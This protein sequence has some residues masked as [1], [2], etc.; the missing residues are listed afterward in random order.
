M[1]ALSR[2]PRA[3]FGWSAA[4]EER[5][6]AALPRRD[7]GDPDPGGRYTGDVPQRD[8]ENARSGHRTATR[9][10]V[11]VCRGAAANG[12]RRQKLCR[13]L[14]KDVELVRE[15]LAAIMNP[16]LEFGATLKSTKDAYG[17]CLISLTFLWC[18][19]LGGTV[20]WRFKTLSV[21][22]MEYLCSH[23]NVVFLSKYCHYCDRFT[24]EK[25]E[26]NSNW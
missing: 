11:P 13:E 14:T 19:H 1:R 12:W 7:P 3:Q 21:I 23:I 10:Q 22:I 9:L 5:P 24:F 18:G 4:T 20:S 17:L 16:L 8:G 26:R 2:R 15:V 6:R 25:N